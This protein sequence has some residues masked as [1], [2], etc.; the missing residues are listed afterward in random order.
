MSVLP[1]SFFRRPVL[2]VAP[3]LLGKILVR[4]L[5]GGKV[6][7]LRIN[8]VEAYDGEQDL[9]CHASRGKTERTAIMYE[10]GG[11][12]YVYLVYGMYYMLNIVT[13]VA[14]YPSAVLIR[15]A[16]H[17]VG[18]GKLTK[19]LKIDRRLNTKR[20]DKESG[21]WIADDGHRVHVRT[22]TRTPRIGVDYAGAWAKKPY[23]YVLSGSS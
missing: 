16:G 7:Q 19:Y 23:R 1:Q 10:P 14:G 4:A 5:P 22:I 9:A 11:A 17:T 20:A 15:G 13:G 12:W 21:L 2:Q 8:E 6:M 3:E 18:P